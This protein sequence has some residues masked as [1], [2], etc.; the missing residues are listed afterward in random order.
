MMLGGRGLT[1]RIVKD[2]VEPTCHPLGKRNK[3]ILAA[4]L[5]AGTPASSSGRLSIGGKSPLT[6][7]IKEANAGGT[8]SGKLARLGLRAVIVEG[9]PADQGPYVV[10]ITKDAAE[11]MPRPDLSLLGVYETAEKLRQ[12]Y[13]SNIGAAIIGPAGEMLLTAAGIANLDP[14]GQ[15][16]RFSAR[17]GLGAVMGSKRVKAI[18]LD[19][20]GCP[21]PKPRNEAE[22]QSALREYT[23]AVLESPQ[24]EVFRK[25]GTSNLVRI[26]NGRAGLPTRN[27]RLGM[28]EEAESISGERLRE[29][30]LE[31]Q[32]QPEHTCM[33]GCVISCSNVY[34]GKDGQNLVSPLEYET[35]GLVGSN[36]MIGDLDA[37]AEINRVC[38]DVGIDT[39]D[40]GGAI[41]LAMEAGLI[42]FGDA[43]G[44]IQLVQEV[45]K[46]SIVGR[47]IGCGGAT[48][49]RLLGVVDAP[50]VKG[51]VMAAYEPRAIKGLGVTYATS[52]MGADH[53]AG[54]TIRAQIDHRSAEGQVEASRKAQ[55]GAATYDSLGLCS[56]VGPA[57]KGDLGLIAKL[58]A[59]RFGVSCS[60][61]DLIEL[62]KATLRT[63]IAFNRAAGLTS[64]Q[65]DLPEWMR[66]T[67]NPSSG[68]VFD[69]PKQELDEIFQSL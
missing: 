28:F 37:I 44:A 68:T 57:M 64:V 9:K 23:K 8:T 29:T 6:G 47:M 5:L 40:A 69:V 16:T 62:G 22:F 33:P 26:L 41:G 51:Q 11:I 56:F 21:R 25:I 18:V 43:Q 42:P 3:L 54:N 52:P 31:R 53:T 66:D 1:S 48:T 30:I 38:N 10:V 2:E 14:E 59:A 17:G 63:E 12:S 39:I 32:G 4:G 55:I 13:G 34:R 19:D 24:T 7:G 15:P 61:E 46:G 60:P 27:F 58:V 20:E 67:E 65:D 50:V 45:G 49:A 36:C 35:I